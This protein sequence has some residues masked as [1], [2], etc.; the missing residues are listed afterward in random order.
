MQTVYGVTV[1]SGWDAFIWNGYL[2]TKRADGTW[3]CRE[4]KL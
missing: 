2:Y 4:W 1:P 3:R